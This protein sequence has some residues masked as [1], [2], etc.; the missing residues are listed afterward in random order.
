MVK[1]SF[2]V[3][4]M[5]LQ[6]A[7]VQSSIYPAASELLCGEHDTNLDLFSYLV[8]Q[9]NRLDNNFDNLLVAAQ[10]SRSNLRRGGRPAP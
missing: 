6:L 8:G 7:H 10:D 2:T 1:L 5:R 3:E 9:L 4:D